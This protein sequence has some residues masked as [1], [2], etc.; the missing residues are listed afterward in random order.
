MANEKW[1]E[2][3]DEKRHSRLET[4]V[5]G[6]GIALEIRFNGFVLFVKLSKVGDKIFD[7]VGM[8]ERIN[9]CLLGGVGGYPT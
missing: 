6:F 3:G 7:H 5:F 9:S 1:V 2:T 4:Y 8:G